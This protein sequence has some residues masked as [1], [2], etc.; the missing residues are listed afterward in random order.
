MSELIDVFDEN[1]EPTGEILEKSEAE[2]Q[3]KWHRAAHIWIINSQGELL[4]Q[5]R[6]PN[7][8]TFPNMWDIS[9]AGH[10]RTGESVVKGGIREMYEELGVKITAEQLILLGTNKS[11]KNQ[12]L[13]TEF[14]IKLDIP[15]ED[16]VFNDNEVA[17]VKYVPWRDL[18]KMSE[19]EM[20]ASNILLHKGFK[21]LFE[22]LQEKGF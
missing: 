11:F 12:H 21:P 4:L 18:A 16:F 13:E 9:A 10:I 19:D 5:K 14:L 15:I 2:R 17:E 20:K 1:W 3:C 22:Y 6:S 8:K 7:K